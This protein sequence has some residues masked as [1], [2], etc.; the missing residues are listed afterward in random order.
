VTNTA[1][2]HFL[3]TNDQASFHEMVRE[4]HGFVYGICRRILGHPA[5]VDDAVQETFIKFAVKAGDIR[6]GPTAWLHTCARTTA[7]DHQR[8]RLRRNRNEHE[9]SK[10]EEKSSLQ[11]HSESERAED[12]WIVDAC[13]A[14]LPEIDREVVTAYFFLDHTQAHIADN[15]GVSQVAIQHRLDRVLEVLRR[16]CV[17]RGMAVSALMAAFLHEA[18]AATDPPVG[19]SE[20]ID[21]AHSEKWWRE[22]Q[23][24]KTNLLKAKIT[25]NIVAAIGAI[26]VIA[27]V[28]ILN[29]HSHADNAPVRQTS[30]DPIP[31]PA[32]A[33]SKQRTVW[34]AEFDD[35]MAGWY[36]D[37]LEKW[38]EN[39]ESTPAIHVRSSPA[40]ANGVLATPSMELPGHFRLEYEVFL[41]E[42]LCPFSGISTAPMSPAGM[43]DREKK[44]VRRVADAELLMNS[45]PARTWHRFRD[46]YRISRTNDGKV[47]LEAETYIDDTFQKAWSSNPREINGSI[48]FVVTGSDIVLTNIHL[49]ELE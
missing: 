47:L 1:F 41:I 46:E 32:P 14:E 31:A 43:G 15:L 33:A 12:L 9:A 5:D 25:L 30:T 17:A 38:V 48:A 23:R 20:A 44:L 3:A 29:R 24:N 40:T 19:S 39:S 18:R 10:Q 21:H 26:A 27:A 42:R 4:Y 34:R 13:L 11:V 35:S 6:S 16:K 7:L 8:A 49:T 36:V 2:Q 22:A 45:L 37:E 28:L